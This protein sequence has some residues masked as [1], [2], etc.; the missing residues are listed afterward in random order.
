MR[1]LKALAWMVSALIGS[2]QLSLPAWDIMFPV[3]QKKHRLW[4]D[5]Q[6]MLAAL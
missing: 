4:N 2:G 6:S 1:H 5:E 3:E